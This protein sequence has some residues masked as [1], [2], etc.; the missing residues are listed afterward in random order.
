MRYVIYGAGA[1][2]GV[3][4]AHLDAARRP[5]ALV[6]RGQHLAA[7]RTDGLTLDTHRG[8]QRVAIPA[9]GSASEISWTAD[10]VVLLC[11]K[12]HQTMAAVND[13]AAHAPAATPVVAVQNGV[14]NERTILRRFAATYSIC[15]GLPATHL[16]PGTVVQ[17]SSGL[18]GILDIGRYPAG[19]DELT[20]AVV[21]DLRA[22]GFASEARTDIMAWKYRKLT[23][24]LANGI[25]VLAGRDD[26]FVE[27]YLRALVEGETVLAAAGIPI[28]DRATEEARRRGLVDG[29]YSRPGGSTWQSVT[30]GSDVEID[31]LTGEI[32]LLGRLHGI[33][34]PV[35][36][37]ILTE[38]HRVV[39]DNLSPG[40]YDAGH[41]LARLDTGDDEPQAS[42]ARAAVTSDRSRQ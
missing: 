26:A 42:A 22:A 8:I 27:L 20:T 33:P 16:E 37:L 32:V 31:Y 14:A 19:V 15:V 38:V 7:L 28:V 2:G 36:D 18:P 29:V 35:N 40:S 17:D 21:A 30:R 9:V 5:V 11:V 10:T 6:A 12:S 4:G 24:N 13:L 39:R 1:V 25:E 23:L 34:T 3:I 41:L